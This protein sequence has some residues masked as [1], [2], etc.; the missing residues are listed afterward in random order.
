MDDAVLSSDDAGG[1]Q[2]NLQLLTQL[3]ACILKDATHQCQEQDLEKLKFKALKVL[4]D[5]QEI[6]S[7]ERNDSKR[8][9]LL[10]ATIGLHQA[11]RSEDADRLL[12]L[13]DK[14]PEIFRNDQLR[15]RNGATAHAE[16]KDELGFQSYNPILHLLL[17]LQGTTMPPKKL[18]Q[19]ASERSSSRGCAPGVF[20]Q[21]LRSRHEQLGKGSR[22]PNV[23]M[24]DRADSSSSV[25]VGVDTMLS[26]MRQIPCWDA[27]SPG[28]GKQA[29]PSKAALGAAGASLM[30]HMEALPDERHAAWNFSESDA[31]SIY[32][33]TGTDN[34]QMANGAVEST[35]CARTK[36]RTEGESEKGDWPLSAGWGC[37]S[38]HKLQEAVYVVNE[39]ILAH[40]LLL[41]LQGVVPAIL[42]LKTGHFCTETLTNAS[43]CNLLQ[44]S[45]CS[46]VLRAGLDAHLSRMALEAASGPAS[47]LCMQA[48]AAAA[49]QILRE[50]SA[51]L[52]SVAESV[53]LRRKADLQNSIRRVTP[54]SLRH[55]LACVGVT[56]A[57]DDDLTVLEVTVHTRA[58]QEELQ[59]LANVCGLQGP[60]AQ[61]S[62]LGCGGTQLLDHLHAQLE[63]ADAGAA[64][65][66]RRLLLA[67]YQ[68]YAEHLE[69]WLFRPGTCMPPGSAFAAAVP[70][71]L[72]SLLPHTA[73]S[74]AV[75]CKVPAFLQRWQEQVVLAG[76]HLSVLHCLPAP[77]NRLAAGLADI[78]ANEHVPPRQDSGS[79]TPQSRGLTVEEDAGPVHLTFHRAEL[80][81]IVVT[82]EAA[83]LEREEFVE[84]E[85][86]AAAAAAAAKRE[87]AHQSGQGAAAGPSP[88]HSRGGKFAAHEPAFLGTMRVLTAGSPT[89][90]HL[91]PCLPPA[92]SPT[93][94][95]SNTNSSGSSSGPARNEARSSSADSDSNEASST[96]STPRAATNPLGARMG[97]LPN[98]GAPQPSAL[99]MVSANGFSKS[100]H[101]GP[102][103]PKP[104][105]LSGRQPNGRASFGGSA[106]CD[107]C[108]DVDEDE[109]DEEAVPLE[110]AVEA[111]VVRRMLS[112][113]ACTGSACIRCLE[114]MG[115][116]DMLAALERYMFMGAGDWAAALVQE[117]SDASLLV[118]LPGPHDL[119]R[120]LDSAILASSA[121]HDPYSAAL[122][123]RPGTRRSL[124]TERRPSALHSLQ[125]G[126]DVRWPLSI[127][128]TQDVRS[129]YNEVLGVLLELR[130]MSFQLQKLW[131]D[132]VHRLGPR[133][134]TWVP[135]ATQQRV[136]ELHCF[137]TAAA[138][139][140]GAVQAY[141]CAQLHSASLPALL[142][143]I[144]GSRDLIE[145]RAAMSRYLARALRACLV[146]ADS[147]SAL[148]LLAPVLQA[149]SD[150]LGAILPA[151]R[152]TD[153]NLA[154]AVASERL[155]QRMRG[156]M[157][158]FD[159]SMRVLVS[160][161]A[162]QE[163]LEYVLA[164]VVMNDHWLS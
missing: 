89:R 162:H 116:E 11:G 131:L 29:A 57:A 148:E 8:V 71:N 50:Q 120:I 164:H 86:A 22:R 10:S 112:Q 97:V 90:P 21:L 160:K 132:A 5:L 158:A 1:L 77:L 25:S 45:I 128:I 155:W 114:Q 151:L 43:L 7:V 55:H 140:L 98:L 80:N 134:M 48:F 150:G 52:Q 126:M 9:E 100:A 6:D 119:P 74:R 146:D 79:E 127:V 36:H 14:L 66:L 95:I 156:P 32:A 141:I 53:R 20:P 81:K 46:G 144:K 60:G 91:S 63:A 125:L 129:Q 108:W 139:V 58:L 99:D 34:G 102:R 105:M 56:A 157:C 124:L 104:W 17:S 87:T 49:I 72:T 109:D 94:P 78:A 12:D 76:L 13:S 121:T 149:I 84:A 123:L 107:P 115:L 61:S 18:D 85:L 137:R 92:V 33:G 19:P 75:P 93:S 88:E 39:G 96:E 54:G 138:Q 41:A 147:Q 24:H 110:A 152:S 67:S 44:P 4:R 136:K 143:D 101:N 133:D 16:E 38:S 145:A 47:D 135:A 68:P 3:T 153:G 31:E 2:N 117:L 111:C 30:Y 59:T 106:T 118:E 64:P 51:A 26:V 83:M 163:V 103:L 159:A 161:S 27:G 113:Y 15:S 82:Q 154:E 42:R 142:Q 37:H 28:S 40:E 23:R 70:A 65:L 73:A 69:D 35:S 122:S 62:G 130:M